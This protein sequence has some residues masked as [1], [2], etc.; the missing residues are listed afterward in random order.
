MEIDCDRSGPVSDQSFLGDP[1]L[2]SALIDAEL[3]PTDFHHLPG[4]AEDDHREAFSVF[5]KSA[6]ALIE[7]RAELRPGAVLVNATSV[8]LMKPDESPLPAQV[9]LDATHLVV[10]LVYRPLQTALLASA[11][12]AGAQTQDGLWMLVEQALLQAQ[13]WLG[14]EVGPEVAPEL[15]RYLASALEHRGAER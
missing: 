8:G 4:W 1:S 5:L 14:L 15:H 13:L 6:E 10:D 7:Q 9:A 3:K 12:R 11:A 2:Y